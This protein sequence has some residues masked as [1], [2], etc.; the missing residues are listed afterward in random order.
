MFESFLGRNRKKESKAM[1][2]EEKT[3]VE[4]DNKRVETDN[5]KELIKE[6][7][8]ED[9]YSTLEMAEAMGEMFYN[10]FNGENFV[11]VTD[12][13]FKVVK[14]WNSKNFN[15]NFKPGDTMPQGT[16]SYEA[17]VSG[18]RIAKQIKK[19]ESKFDFGYAGI[20]IPIKD[21][22]H[23]I[24][25]SLAITFLYIDPQELRGVAEEMQTASDQNSQ[26]TGEIAAGATNLSTSSEMLT[27]NTDLA[28]NS[29]KT[30]NDVIELIKGVA[31]QTNL[32]ALNAAIEAARAGEHGKGFAVVAEEVRKLAQ[33][34]A[35]RAKDMSEKLSTISK[36][37]EDIGEKT[38]DLNS[39]AQ[40]QAASTEEINASMEQLEEQ[41]RKILTLAAE[42][43]KGLEFMLK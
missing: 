27:H 12:A 41:A 4:T 35:D 17:L 23:N 7:P 34:S 28:R 37:I 19:T 24:I 8:T 5:K 25:G 31:E 10:M 38:Q 6:L 14:C 43:E 42:L 21:K 2:L 39:L 9:Y 3:R 18:K 36:M 29:L 26:A 20:G 15:F 22:G 40:Q 33:N 1:V 30:I 11:V 13:N 32:L 16:I